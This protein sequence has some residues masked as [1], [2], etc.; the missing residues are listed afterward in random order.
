MSI[1]RG[2]LYSP[3]S[4]LRGSRHGTQFFKN[5][6]SRVLL[7]SAAYPPEVCGVGDYTRHLAKRLAAR[8]QVD[9]AVLTASR[10]VVQGD[11]GPEILRAIGGSIG[12]ID[13]WRAIRRFRPTIVHFQYPTR[14]WTSLLAPLFAKLAGALPVVQTWHEYSI[15]QGRMGLLTRLGLDGLIYVRPDLPAKVSIRSRRRIKVIPASYIPNGRTVPA[16]AL[17]ASERAVARAEISGGASVVAFFGFVYPNK[18][19]HLLFEI[20][21]PE[22]HHLLFIGDLQPHIEYQRHI[23]QLADSERWRG[24]VTFTGYASAEQAGRLLALSDAAVFPFPD[25]IGPWNSSVNAAIASGS[26]VV[27]TTQDSGETGYHPGRNLYLGLAGDVAGLRAGL[28][29]YLGARRA[30]D[31]TDDWDSIADAHERF[32]KQ[33]A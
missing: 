32:Y 31:L 11:G 33:F 4:L 9:A 27:A 8:R 15:G 2:R 24:R 12:M 18:G 13:V 1:L 26:L 22:R 16:I 23:R 28:E 19:A 21:D 14:R 29:E 5:M 6:T 10:G 3:R 17:S 25:G 20:A 7:I 30:P